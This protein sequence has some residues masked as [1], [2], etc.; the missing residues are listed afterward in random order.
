MATLKIDNA[1]Y[2]ITLDPQRRILRD[3]TV[4]IDGQYITHVDKAEALRHV[5]AE[6]VIDA[7]EMVVTPGFCNNHM[8]I[9]YAHATRGIFPDDLDPMV[10]LAHV[11]TLQGAMNEEDEYYTSLLGI[12]ELLKY[13]TTCFLDPGSTKYLDA[14]LQAYAES[15]C[16]IV[17]GQ[18]VVDR[19]NPFHLPVYTTEAAIR[20]MEETLQRYHGQLDGRV[21]AWTM[22]FDA[23]FCSDELLTAAKALADRYGTGMTLHQAN[24]P[25]TVQ[26][27][28]ADYGKRPVQYLDDL[29]VLGPNV[30]LAHVIDLDEAEIEAI[31]RSGTKT[32]MCP[33]AALK[34]GSGMT[35][36][37]KLPEMVARGICVSLGTDAGNNSNLLETLRAMYLVAVVYKD[38]RRTTAVV[39]A[40]L[41]LELATLE[42]A[43]ALGLEREIGSIE[44]GKKADLVLF[45]T[46]R[47]EWRTLFNPVNSLVYNADGRSVHTVIVDGRVVVREARPCYIDEWELI[48][49]VQ[50]LGERLL[51]RTGIHFAP[52]WP[53]M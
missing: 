45:D 9:S 18:Q 37:A 21:R 27:Y 50:T 46:R 2:L 24:R 10:Y 22:P 12:T 36:T 43:R 29:G 33:T 1:R 6:E 51:Q 14:C 28:L 16:R 35:A 32:V 38:A 4:V 11:F 7:R 15:G 42:G 52:R 25:A 13:G 20:R 47:P 40:E 30:L 17:V 31:A 49:K 41:A 34:M 5:A 48:C 23:A 26:R 3:A 53:V 39:P 19:P 44:V 8:H